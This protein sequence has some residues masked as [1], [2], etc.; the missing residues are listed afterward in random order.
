MPLTVG[1]AGCGRVAALHLSALAQVDG[2]DAVAVYDVDSGR[3]RDVAARFD[4]DRVASD[5]SALVGDVD[6]VA[7]CAP[8]REHASVAGAALAAGRHVLVE[9]PLTLAVE[10]ADALIAAAPAGVVACTGFNLRVH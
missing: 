8:P 7:V 10:D 4:V 5:V 2:I 6:V 9:K 1:I 3:A